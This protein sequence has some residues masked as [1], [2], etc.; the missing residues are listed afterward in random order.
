M[1]LYSSSN[2]F[3][4]LSRLLDGRVDFSSNIAFETAD[5]VMLAHSLSGSTLQVSLAP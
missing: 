4:H 1:L 2:F 3:E 5:D